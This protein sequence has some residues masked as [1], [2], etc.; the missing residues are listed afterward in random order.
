MMIILLLSLTTLVRSADP[1]HTYAMIKPD[2]VKKGHVE[3]ILQR[4]RAEGFK[5]I[6]QKEWAISPKAAQELYEEHIP[7][8]KE[9]L[10][11]AQKH[12]CGR[13]ARDEI[14]ARARAKCD[15]KMKFYQDICSYMQEGPVVSLVLEARNAV[16]KWRDLI[17]FCDPPTAMKESIKKFGDDRQ[18][19]CLRALFGD[20]SD[21]KK[22][23]DTFYDVN[24]RPPRCRRNAVHGADSQKAAAREIALVE[25]YLK[26]QGDSWEAPVH[27]AKL[28]HCR[29]LASTFP[30]C[31]ACGGTGRTGLAFL[32]SCSN[33]FGTGKTRN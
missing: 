5:I 3:A 14:E 22:N 29:R 21:P 15:N 7:K 30:L 17:G 19:W 18:K 1:E 6:R 28:R 23:P 8:Y 27:Q 13:L 32:S 9:Y 26:L 16:Q 2:A 4:I 24:R 20:H 12:F 25:K 11:K 31:V 10:A 33:C